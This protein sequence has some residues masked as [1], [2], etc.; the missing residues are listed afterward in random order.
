MSKQTQK[1]TVR[2]PRASGPWDSVQPH[3]HCETAV[4]ECGVDDERCDGVACN[5]PGSSVLLR[6]SFRRD[7]AS[8][9]RVGPC[10]SASPLIGTRSLSLV[11]LTAH[12]CCNP[13]LTSFVFFFPLLPPSHPSSPSHPRAS[14]SPSP[15][16]RS[17]TL[18]AKP[19][20][21]GKR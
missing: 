13:R 9:G 14:S 19:A 17:Q 1:S 8:F 20:T 6:P 5:H 7:P 4:C 11:P 2:R 15:C 12:G 10:W 3:A 21:A 16:T 18:Q